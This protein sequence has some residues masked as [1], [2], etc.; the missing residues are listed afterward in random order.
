MKISIVMTAYNMENYI[1]QAIKS[2][3]N[4]THNDIELI[5]VEDCSTD[6]TKQIIEYYAQEDSRVRIIYHK[7]NLGAGLGRR[8]GIEAATG[9]Y[10]ITVDADDW[11]DESFIQ[12]LVN[13]AE[14]TSADIVSGGITIERGNGYWEKTCYGDLI[15]YD[16][17]KVVKFWGEK[18]VFMNNKIIKTSLREKVQY[19]KRRFIED[20]PTI[21]PM[22][23]YANMVAY[24]SDT[25]YHYRMQSNS[26]THQADP[27]KYALYRSLCCLDLIDFFEENDKQ[28]LS[29]LPIVA[30]L[31]QQINI[32][33]KVQNNEEEI[34]KYLDEWV[35]FTMRLLARK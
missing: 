9:E 4:Q 8:H 21:I 31:Q 29:K 22:L 2:C 17:D 19:C 13:T 28:L 16:D 10:F 5:I 3:L 35:E 7:E 11:L 32:I 12:S 15:T 30:M 18:V 27:F 6:N 23:W 24:T 33:K 14:E 26:L 25:G 34:H 20:T 1:T